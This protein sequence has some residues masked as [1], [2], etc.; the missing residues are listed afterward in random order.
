MFL[1]PQK[2]TVR[3]KWS[4][5][6][7]KSLFESVQRIVGAYRYDYI[8][9]KYF[10]DSIGFLGPVNDGDRIEPSTPHRKSRSYGAPKGG[11]VAGAYCPANA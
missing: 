7:R 2:Q 8:G 9:A 10:N 11:E 1:G 3:E 4:N 6:V 5:K